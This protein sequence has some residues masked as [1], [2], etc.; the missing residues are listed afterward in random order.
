PLAETSWA[1]LASRTAAAAEGLRTLGVRPGDRVVAYMANIEET[2]AA[3]LACASLG[4]IWSSCSPDFGVRAVVDRFSQI[5]P[6]LL[7]AVAGSRSGGRDF[8]R[9]AHVAEISSALPTLEH[10]ICVPYLQ[11]AARLDDAIG[12]G[13]LLERGAGAALSFEQLPFAHPLW[14]LHSSGTTG[15]PKPIVHGQGGILLELLK[16]LPLHP[17]PP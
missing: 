10:T 14:V 15:L 9:T 16:T 17:D 2:V 7:L 13:R 1:E 8:D 12:W 6:K 4:A 3:F 5:D 11:G